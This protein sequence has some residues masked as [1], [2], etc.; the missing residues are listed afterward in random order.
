MTAFPKMTGAALGKYKSGKDL[1]QAIEAGGT[2]FLGKGEHEVTLA[3]VDR[4][5]LPE[6]KVSFKYVDAAGR[7]HVDQV[8]FLDQSPKTGEWDIGWK[9]QATLG[10]LIP[11]TEAYEAF[12][13]EVNAGNSEVLDCLVGLR[14]KIELDRIKGFSPSVAAPEGGFY[15]YNV[16]KPDEKYYGASIEDAEAAAKN[17]GLKK[18]FMNVKRYVATEGEANVL[19]FSDNMQRL[20]APKPA[21]FTRPK[22]AVGSSSV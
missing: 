12:L 3:G 1:G 17:A 5:H 7:D 14:G 8:F 6:N 2:K 4:N 11:S 22:L 15:V 19:K 9:I 20:H 16:K 10:M 13:A 18:A 21:A